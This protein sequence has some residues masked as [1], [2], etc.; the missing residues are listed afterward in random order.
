MEKG[1]L[2]D[3]LIGLVKFVS[4]LH[5][6]SPY[7]RVTVLHDSFKGKTLPSH[8]IC[9]VPRYSGNTFVPDLSEIVII[10]TGRHHSV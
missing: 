8:Y 4:M 9:C 3:R 1:R 10:G 2:V 6:Q 5:F 7:E